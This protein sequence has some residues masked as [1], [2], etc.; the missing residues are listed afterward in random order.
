MI[1][2]FNQDVLCAR[3]PL[4]LPQQ[5]LVLVAMLA[6][7]RADA[8]LYCS[9]Y[10]YGKFTL[11]EADGYCPVPKINAAFG[12]KME[13]CS[14]SNVEN[15][16]KRG[17]LYWDN[18]ADC[19][20][21]AASIQGILAGCTNNA[22]SNRG[23]CEAGDE[24]DR[25]NWAAYLASDD[26]YYV[27]TC[28]AD[29]GGGWDGKECELCNVS[30]SSSTTTLTTTASTTIAIAASTT[31]TNAIDDGDG[32]V[33]KKVLPLG[34]IVGAAAGTVVL[35]VAVIVLRLRQKRR[36]PDNVVIRMQNA[37]WNPDNAA[38]DD[39]LLDY[40][41]GGEDAGATTASSSADGNAV[42]ET[43][44]VANTI[45]LGM[46]TQAAA[47]LADLMGFDDMS[48]LHYIDGHGGG[49]DAIIHEIN[50][51]GTEADKK[52]LRTLLDGTYTNPP[53]SKG[54]PQTPE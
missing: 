12:G 41:H 31:T 46:A 1:A 13:K 10:C 8:N 24:I 18:E 39:A 19:L 23:T 34:I 53:D 33:T 16:V 52:N 49:S 29:L 45:R 28:N 22:C 9:E 36:H 20:K 27:C 4:L 35:L 43:K 30:A 5:V 42:A 21:G 40:E 15:W 47:G 2:R 26:D 38:D 3:S 7:R 51:N 54:A 6:T 14:H 17:R 44:F 32:D 25:K 50:K 11:G 48:L 37:V